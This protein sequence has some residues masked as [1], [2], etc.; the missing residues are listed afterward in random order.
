MRVA[1]FGTRDEKKPVRAPGESTM[2]QVQLLTAGILIA[3]GI[4]TTV[5]ATA[6]PLTVDGLRCE[7]RVNPM[8]VDT[9]APRLSWV[10]SG[11]ERGAAQSAYRV[12]VA[13]DPALLQKNEGNLWDSGKVQS[14]RTTQIPYEGVPLTSEQVCWWKV[15]AWNEK[16]EASAWSEPAFW[17]MGLLHPEDWK[18]TWIGL[19]ENGDATGHPLKSLLE[20]A[21][22]IWHGEALRDG[23]AVPGKCAVRVV[24]NLPADRKVSEA[25]AAFTADNS[26]VLLVNGNNAGR[27]DNFNAVTVVD[28]SGLLKPGAN[29]IAGVAEN[30]GDNPNP[31]GV[32]A[33]IQVVFQDGGSLEVV[34]D[35]SWQTA[36]GDGGTDWATAETAAGGSPA[37]EL[38]GWDIQPWGAPNFPDTRRLPARMLRKEF[39]AGNGIRRATAYLCGLGLFECYVNGKKVGD[40]VLDP[41]LSE[42]DKRVYYQTFDVTDMVRSGVNAVGAWLGNGRYYAPRINSPTFT[43]TYGYPKLLFQLRL[44]YAN[45]KSDLVVSDETWKL[46]TD[47]PIRANNEYDG[48]EYDARMEIPGWSEPGFDDHAWRAA[49]RV[50]APGGVL[51][52]Q[53]CEPIRVTQTLKPVAVTEPKPGVYIFD[54]GQNMV[55][56]CR[57]RVSGPAGT[58]V[59]LR[60]AEVLKEDGTL[61]LANI[62]DAKVTDIYTLKGEGVEAWEPRFT[63]HGFRYVEVTGLPEKP[64]LDFL[65]GR[66]VHD[67]LRLAGSFECSHPLVNQI[68]RNVTWGV[69]GNYRSIPTDCPQRDERQGWLGDRS[70]ECK[71]ESYLFDVAALYAKWVADMDD[72]QREDGSVSDVCPSYWPLY[73]DNVT[74]PSTFIIAPDMVYTQYGDARVFE[75]HY[76]GMKQWIE[77]MRGYIK[78]GLLPKDSYGDWCVPPESPEL[79]HS[80]DPARKTPPEL[81]GTA[82]FIY[83]LN[84]M[85]K[86]AGLLGKDD[87]R[88]AFQ[89]LAAEMT[90][91]FNKALWNTEHG[92]YG[93]GSQ[94]SQVLALAFNIA[95]ESRWQPIF[96]HLV[97]KITGECDNHIGTGLIGGQWLMRTLTRFGRADL[98]WTITT[99][100][101]YPSWGYMVRKNATT[102]WELWNG[103]TADPAMNSHNHVM[104]VGDLVIWFYEHL[105]G[106]APDPD[107]PGFRRVIMRPVPVPGLDW[108]K[109]WH[110]APVGRIASAWSKDNGQFQ[111]QVTIPAGTRAVIYIPT[112]GKGPVTEGGKPLEQAA[113]ITAVEQAEGYVQCEAGSGSYAFASP[114]QE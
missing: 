25:R 18:A 92:W 15:Q 74:W 31:A 46:T 106:I 69:R 41:A 95:P 1:W 71:G 97:G 10:V 72:A 73:N 104:L 86:Y 50:D 114:W 82:Y 32:I 78:D 110:E 37:R 79:I 75:A 107:N 45:G 49:Q 90:E 111:W 52:S 54:M 81:L 9:T 26:M 77:H 22:W 89:S 4:L 63:Y 21:K 39:E 48:E 64:G 35:G 2:K 5:S 101:T 70:A 23:G 61:Y 102:I 34:S 112:R 28:I 113:G 88:Q 7:Y 103:D 19:D 42:Y 6:A 38:G 87:D 40:H 62:R 14:D 11:Q 84:L 30:A 76:E 99:Q 59:R 27:A 16:N 8:G 66:V 85:T 55:G 91:A 57:I 58:Q 96:D 68:Y 3:W 105:A 43:R 36:A 60:H 108:V 29:V 67:D 20:K 12:L 51:R 80:K 109:A 13:S 56:W 100:D 65:E 47:G 98:G 53:P 24:I 17:T 94:T 33:G 93:N 83:D 44:E